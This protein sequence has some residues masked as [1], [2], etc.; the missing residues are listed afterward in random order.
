VFFKVP[1]VIFDFDSFSFQVPACGSAAR[2]T[3]APK[4]ENTRVNPTALIFMDAS[5]Q[6][7]DETSM[8]FKLWT[9]TEVTSERVL[10][11]GCY[12]L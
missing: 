9:A 1:G 5:R 12:R 3:A 11:V 2:H 6:D 8:P 4:K 7:F 10:S